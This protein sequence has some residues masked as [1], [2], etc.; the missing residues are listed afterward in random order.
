MGLVV[1][2]VVGVGVGVVVVVV[3]A[4]AVLV[5]VVV[6]VVTGC[7]CN[8]SIGMV[9]ATQEVTSGLCFVAAAVVLRCWCPRHVAPC[10]IVAL[11]ACRAMGRARGLGGSFELCSPKHI[12]TISTA[13]FVDH[14]VRCAP[15]ASTALYERPSDLANLQSLLTRRDFRRNVLPASGRVPSRARQV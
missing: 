11:A 9:F 4:V 12:A 6:V 13:D 2:I 1:V 8:S 10:R 7:A 5:V 14:R 3:V 15:V